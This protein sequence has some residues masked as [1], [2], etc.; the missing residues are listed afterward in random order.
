MTIPTGKKDDD[1]TDDDVTK[2]PKTPRAPKPVV[3]EEESGINL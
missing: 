1:D 3:E 2:E